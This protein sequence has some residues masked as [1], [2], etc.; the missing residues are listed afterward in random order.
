MRDRKIYLCAAFCL[1]L[2]ALRF[3]FPA[4]TAFVQEWVQRTADPAGII[5]TFSQELGHEM[6][7]TG[8]REGLIAVFR[9]GEEALS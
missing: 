7:D 3:L 4:Q 9:L 5:R 1:L 8:L 2:A 6:G